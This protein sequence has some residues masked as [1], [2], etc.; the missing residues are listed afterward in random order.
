MKLLKNHVLNLRLLFLL[1]VAFTFNGCVSLTPMPFTDKSNK[2]EFDKSTIGI[3]GI[4]VSNEFKPHFQP[5]V[6]SFRIRSM[7]KPDGKT[8]AF[9]VEVPENSIEKNYNE[10]LV[11]FELAPG[12]YRFE[13]F[14][15]SARSFPIVGHFQVPVYS[16][17]Q[18]AQNQIQYFGHITAKV[19][20]RKNDKEPRA[21][22]IVPLIDQAV[23]GFS[24][25][26][27]IV[28]LSDKYEKDIALLHNKYPY[29]KKYKIVKNPIVLS[30]IAPN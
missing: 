13:G 21:G 30:T 11:S 22:S 12:K 10:Y 24:N 6:K 23:A 27:F 25:G 3:L 20:E 29:L 19:V 9:E 28:E 8:V 4:K 5:F 7:D 14:F 15:G 18:L 16:E 1:I 2:K 26:T 17:F